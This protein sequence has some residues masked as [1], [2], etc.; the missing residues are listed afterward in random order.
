MVASNVTTT[1]E[2]AKQTSA[3]VAQAS[4]KANAIVAN[5][6][7]NDMPEVR[8]TVENTWDM[9]GQFDQA[10]GTFLAKGP[11]NENTAAAL[12][13]TVHGA[14]KTVTNLAD[15]IEAVKHNFFLRGFFKRR[16]FYNLDQITPSKYLAS[17]F[18]KKPKARVWVAAA[19]VIRVATRRHAETGENGIGD[20]GYPCP[21]WSRIFRTT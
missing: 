19:G 18:A 7:Q 1:I 12:R 8:K 9:T 21:I 20:I 15:D 16:G 4:Q 2:N 17:Q 10:V 13:D 3:N 11:H 5:V 6:Q 14:Q